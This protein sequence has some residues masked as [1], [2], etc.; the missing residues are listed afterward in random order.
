[1]IK[2][3]LMVVAVLSLSACATRANYEAALNSWIGH[4]E[5]ELVGAWG[6]PVNG[7]TAPDGVRILTYNS[8]GQMTLPGTPPSYTTNC[9]G[10]TCYTNPVGGT[11]PTTINLS[12]ATNFTVT[13]GV[14]STWRYQ[15]NNCV[16]R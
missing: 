11:R 1:M 14:I 10:N 6:P 13:N 16:S 5:S 9:V 4:P 15:G 3:L 12:C 2:K 8:S 7:Y